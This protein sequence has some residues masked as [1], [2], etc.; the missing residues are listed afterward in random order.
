VRKSAENQRLFNALRPYPT[1]LESLSQKHWLILDN[2]FINQ[3]KFSATLHEL[4]STWKG[5]GFKKVEP[6]R[7]TFAQFQNLSGQPLAFATHPL[8]EPLTFTQV[9]AWATFAPRRSRRSSAAG[10]LKL[11]PCRRVYL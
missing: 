5:Y 8:S 7:P 2:P 10:K 3:G 4:L 11:F 9:T 1:R 6:R